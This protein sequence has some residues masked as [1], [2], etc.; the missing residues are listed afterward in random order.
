MRAARWVVLLAALLSLGFTV[1]HNHSGETDTYRVSVG[2]LF[3]LRCLSADANVTWS[4]EGTHNQSLPTGVEVRD[5][6]LWFLPVQVSHNGS[7]T[8]ETRGTTGPSRV[9]FGVSVS[10]GECPDPPE[11]KTLTKGANQELPCKQSEILNLENKRNITWM[12]DCRPM[13]QAEERISVDESGLMRFA[14][15]S[16]RDAGTYTCL[17]DIILDGKKYTAARSTRLTIKNNTFVTEPE[18]VFPQNEVVVVEEGSTVQLKCFAYV[19]F[20][21]NK[22]TSI[23][24]TVDGVDTEDDEEL[25]DSWKYTHDRGKV[26]GLSILSI[27]K[28]RQR[29]LNVPIHCYVSNSVG[30]A[31]GVVWL[32]EAD[33]SAVYTSV[34]LCLAASLAVLA[35][36]ASVLFFKVELVLAHR[37]LLRHFFSKQKAPDGKLYDAYVSFLHPDGLSSSETQR[38]ALQILPDELEKKDGYSLYIRGRDDCPGEA[39]HDAI[40][41]TVRQCRRLILI[42]SSEIKS[43]ND[44]KTEEAVL[45]DNQDHLWYEQKVGLYDALTQKEPRVILVEIDGPL[46]YSCLSE[47]LRYIKRKQGA[48]KWKKPSQET[49]K[50]LKLHSNRNFWKH[51]RYHMPSVP[52]G[53]VQTIV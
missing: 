30:Q 17:V 2:R 15:A 1:A 29:F 7:Y 35:L 18:V 6:L 16:E 23:Y 20:S 44:G 27:S 25:S 19:G 51:L 26:Y 50:L 9:T 34:A 38:F 31:V 45:S 43:S 49:H 8:C 21:E 37:K 22:L 36:A 41:A 47:S 11:T 14:P 5:S 40:A 48:L 33:R 10:R 39:V 24:W 3:V 28:V 4:S 46:D 12:K 52:A 13:K 53:R 32:Q 42:L